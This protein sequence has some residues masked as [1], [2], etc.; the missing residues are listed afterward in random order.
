M[1]TAVHLHLLPPETLPAQCRCRGCV[2]AGITQPG[3][4]VNAVHPYTM[5]GLGA[6]LMIGTP[7]N[8]RCVSAT[9]TLTAAI[10][11]QLHSLP[12]G[13]PR[14]ACVTT[15]STTLRGHTV[16]AASYTSSGTG[17]RVRP[18]RRPVSPASVTLTGQCQEHHAILRLDSACARRMCRGNAVTCVGLV[19]PDSATPT[20]GAAGAVNAVPWA[21]GL[22]CPVMKRVAAAY[23]CPMYWA[24]AVTSVPPTTGSWLAARAVSRAPVT[25]AIP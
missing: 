17:A 15:V 18:P 6:L 13:A 9:G 20:L 22:T 19:S 12:V 5:V 14:V 24:P 21:P 10:L 16:N 8:A 2:F 7:R 1:L 4:T 25:P 23:V 11:T 3:P